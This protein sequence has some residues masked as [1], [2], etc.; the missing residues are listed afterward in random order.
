MAKILRKGHMNP[1]EVSK[2]CPI[3]FYGRVLAPCVF[4]RPWKTSKCTRHGTLVSVHRN[5]K[6]D[7]TS[8][9]NDLPEPYV[10]EDFGRLG[11]GIC[12]VAF[13]IQASGGSDEESSKNLKSPFEAT[14]RIKAS[15]FR[16]DFKHVTQSIFRKVGVKIFRRCVLSQDVTFPMS[17]PIY[18]VR[19]VQ[20]EF[21][22]SIWIALFGSVSICSGGRVFKF[23][24]CQCA[25]PCASSFLKRAFAHF[26]QLLPSP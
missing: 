16:N 4:W 13:A 24:K 6:S 26:D 15:W 7:S 22:Y 10:I 19:S 14:V 2:P 12:P 20:R 25:D 9:F 23:C 17:Y 5:S 3:H 21:Q 1:H 11:I 8:E 18:H